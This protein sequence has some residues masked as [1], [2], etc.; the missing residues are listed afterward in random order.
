MVTITLEYNNNIFVYCYDITNWVPVC[1]SGMHIAEH[2]YLGTAYFPL[3]FFLN[4]FFIF[5][6]YIMFPIHVILLHTLHDDFMQLTVQS[7]GKIRIIFNLWLTNTD[8]YRNSCAICIRE[9]F[10]CSVTRWIFSVYRIHSSYPILF[11][12]S[13][14]PGNIHCA[15]LTKFIK[16]ANIEFS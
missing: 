16:A 9:L 10:R 2:R 12:P 11:S 8:N 7:T 1:N 13:N 3:P 15:K 5:L 4:F 6:V 14:N